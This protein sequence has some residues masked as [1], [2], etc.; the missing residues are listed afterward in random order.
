MAVSS[1]ATVLARTVTHALVGLDARRVR[2]RGAPPARRSGLRD[3]RPG[4]SRLPGGEG[5][6]SVRDSL[7]R[8]RV[9]GPADHRQPRAGRAPEGRVRLRPAD[10]PGRAGGLAAGAAEA[11]SGHAAVG[12]LALDGRLRPVGGVLAA[13]EGRG[14]PGSRI[15]SARPSRPQRPHWPGRARA[16]A[17]PGGGGRLPARRV[18][19]ASPDSLVVSNGNGSGPAVPGPRRRARPGACAAGARARGR[20]RPQPALGGPPGTGK[21]ML[22]RRLPGILP[23]LPPD[24]ALE[25]RASTP[26]PGCSR[27]ASRS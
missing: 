10:R 3:R 27:R 14:R 13:A 26:S 15:C 16:G 7:R 25:S 24:E 17:P 5:A 18:A 8:A 4:R 21:T 6:R 22:A 9:A 20:G 11:L 12:E 19:A 1:V 23:R 2:G